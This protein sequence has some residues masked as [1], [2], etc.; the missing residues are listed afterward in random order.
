MIFIYILFA[1][2][3]VIA[4]VI[5]LPTALELS[6]ALGR[7]TR[8]WIIRRDPANDI[9]DAVIKKMDYVADMEDYVYY[10]GPGRVKMDHP[11]SIAYTFLRDA[12]ESMKSTEEE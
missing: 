12:V 6:E 5:L 10:T 4:G 1:A 7:Y 2:A 11:P 3:V 8:N 9:I